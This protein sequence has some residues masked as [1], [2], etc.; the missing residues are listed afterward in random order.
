M[1]D[2]DTSL[3]S[4]LEYS[5]SDI[6]PP[7]VIFG[8]S[9]ETTGPGQGSPRSPR[10][11]NS[12]G[13]PLL[14]RLDSD[15]GYVENC[16]PEDPDFTVVIRQAETAIEHGIFPERI[17]QGS[18]GSYFVKSVEGVSLKEKDFIANVFTSEIYRILNC[19]IQT[20]PFDIP[21]SM[22]FWNPFAGSLFL[23]LC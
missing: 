5:D 1:V 8:P 9:G 11:G 21:H 10:R 13:T 2:I 16:F 4:V 14:G 15:Y 19:I 20:T 22:L 17:S 23:I 7:D 6:P 3:N 18:S 12:E